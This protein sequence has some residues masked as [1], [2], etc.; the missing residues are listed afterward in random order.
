MSAN[1]RHVLTERQI[2]LF[3]DLRAIEAAYNDG[4]RLPPQP[5]MPHDGYPHPE[6]V[7]KPEPAA[8]SGADAQRFVVQPQPSKTASSDWGRQAAQ[9]RYAPIPPLAPTAPPA[10]VVP[11]AHV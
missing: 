8:L 10:F 4:Y 6:T 9:Q 11:P 1:T 7:A 3:R 2:E 5:F